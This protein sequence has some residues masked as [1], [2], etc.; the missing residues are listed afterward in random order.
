MFNTFGDVR[1]VGGSSS[2]EGQVEVY[3]LDVWGNVC[4]DGSWDKREAQVVCRQLGLPTAN[5][6]TLPGGY[7]GSGIGEL[8]LHNWRC[9]GGEMRMSS[10]PFKYGWSKPFN[11]NCSY[12]NAAG[13]RCGK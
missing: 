13:V 1:L 9:S 5:V 2:R 12:T 10:C 8:M 6:V 3:S 7:F 4:D 11:P